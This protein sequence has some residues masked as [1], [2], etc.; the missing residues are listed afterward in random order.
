MIRIIATWAGVVG[1]YLVLAP[2]VRGQGPVFRS[3]VDI[4]RVY[5]TVT[6]G[7]GRLVTD[8]SRED[9]EI[10]E[11]G[12]IQPIRVFSN[13]AVPIRLI[14][15]LDISTSMSN[16][17]TLMREGAEALLM[18]LRPDDAARVGTFS[19]HSMTLSPTFTNDFGTLRRAL[20]QRIVSGGTWLYAALDGALNA[21]GTERGDTR[22]VI[23]A[24]SDGVTQDA[25]KERIID[26]AL[27]GDVMIYVI[28]M[29]KLE[30][31][32]R[33]EEGFTAIAAETGGGFME[34]HDRRNVSTAFARVADE[35]HSQY[36][37]GFE[38]PKRDGR[39]HQID[40]RSKRR[41]MKIRASRSYV[42]PTR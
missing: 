12:E 16:N 37:L 21:F 23:V 13:T 28:T 8:L 14:L 36:L 31:T 18:R 15:L 42:A 1:I 38:P 33:F 24:F 30:D 35:L 32:S 2:S 34:L 25:G 10:K 11:G 26:R 41:G 5:A 7:E 6:N 40:V 4:V 20:P 39:V 19:G 9:F 3:Q 27:S 29:P 22:R 17:F